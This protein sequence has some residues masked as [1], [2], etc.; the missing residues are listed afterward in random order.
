MP[1]AVSIELPP[2]MATS[3]SHPCERYSVAPSSTSSTPGFARTLTNTTGSTSE[4]RSDSSA[5]SSSPA[6]VTILFNRYL[7]VDP[8]QV[9]SLPAPDDP[10]GH[11]DDD[12]DDVGG[13]E[14]VNRVR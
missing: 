13:Q 4:R 5:T 6:A 12:R 11:V 8:A 10:R 3:P 2:P 7:V 9:D 14:V 1:L